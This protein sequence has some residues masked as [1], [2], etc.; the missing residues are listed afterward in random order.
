MTEHKFTNI[1]SFAPPSEGSGEAS[2]PLLKSF[3]DHPPNGAL[4]LS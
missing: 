3:Q 4:Q 2:N 1:R